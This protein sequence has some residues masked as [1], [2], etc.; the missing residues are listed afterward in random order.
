MKKSF[1]HL[2]CPFHPIYFGSASWFQFTCDES[3]LSFDIKIFQTHYTKY[4]NFK[5]N[6][7]YHNLTLILIADFCVYYYKKHKESYTTEIRISALLK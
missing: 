4:L 1:K 3:E 7:F 5:F 6:L 2:S